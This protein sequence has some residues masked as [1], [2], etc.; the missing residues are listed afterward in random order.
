[1]GNLFPLKHIMKTEDIKGVNSISKR[2]RFRP[3]NRHKKPGGLV[4]I[5]SFIKP[6]VVGDLHSNLDNLKK[7]ISH[8]GNR[9]RL[10]RRNYVL[11]ILGDAVHN[12]QI[13]QFKEMKSSLEILEYI[14]ELILQYPHRVIYLR[15]N[16]DSFDERLV[17]SGIA[18]GLEFRNYLLQKR[19]RSFVKEVELFF[20]SLPV[21]VISEKYVITH[22]GPVR[23]GLTR[24]ELIN[25]TDYPDQYYQLMWNRINEFRGTP[26]NREYNAHDIQ[27]TLR[28]LDMPED[29]LFIVG[30]NPL[31]NTGDTTG[32][33][34]N[35]L[36]IKNHHILYS[37]S[38]T[39]A[40]YFIINDELEVY[41]AV[42]P[43]KKVLY[44]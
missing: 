28:K 2:S 5:P 37:G 18:Q 39:L 33:W 12:D 6:I 32:I 27:E 31:W 26:S 23:G 9:K 19:S 44:V 38:N 24:E 42:E 3:K 17:K 8:N 10:N 25:I 16:H 35:V 29:S 14:F 4:E 21:F 43:E 40:P 36:G 1:M 34:L 11:V 15:G 7:I 22:A 20:N 13:G 30:H 41:F